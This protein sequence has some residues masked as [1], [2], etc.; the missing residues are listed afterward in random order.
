MYTVLPR[1]VYSCDRRKV[2]APNRFCF[3]CKA[4]H[5][6]S[7]IKSVTCVVTDRQTVTS[8]SEFEHVNLPVRTTVPST[9]DM[10]GT[11]NQTRAKKVTGTSK[12][13]PRVP[14][15]NRSQGARTGRCTAVTVREYIVQ[16]SQ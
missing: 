12:M 11:I 6:I 7:E 15:G 4:L 3:D 9:D 5:L 10:T 1:T 16:H 14:R 2:A 8:Q 13:R